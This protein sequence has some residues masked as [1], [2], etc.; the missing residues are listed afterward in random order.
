MGQ[1]GGTGGGK[2]E[3]LGRIDAAWVEGVAFEY[4]ANTSPRTTHRSIAL[5]RYDEVLATG[6]R[7]PASRPPHRTKAAL[8]APDQANEQP[9][10]YLDKGSHARY[11]T[12]ST[13]PW[14]LLGR[15]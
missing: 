8:V 6:W 13:P 1:K 11:S 4:S 5:H 10:W 3:G 9:G 15:L 2:Q 14:L 12:L 7:E